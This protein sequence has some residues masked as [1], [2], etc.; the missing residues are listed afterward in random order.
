MKSSSI[1]RRAFAALAFAF[2]SLILGLGLFMPAIALAEDKPPAEY[3]LN[4]SD[5]QQ[6]LAEHPMGTPIEISA[7]DL[8]EMDRENSRRITTWTEM[9]KK[10][11][12]LALYVQRFC[13]DMMKQF[14]IETP[15]AGDTRLVKRVEPCHELEALMQVPSYSRESRAL[16]Y[17]IAIPQGA[18]TAKAGIFTPPA[19]GMVWYEDSDGDGWGDKDKSSYRRRGLRHAVPIKGDCDDR[20]AWVSP[21][22]SEIPNGIDDNCDRQIDEGYTREDASTDIRVQMYQRAQARLAANLPPENDQDAYRAIVAARPMPVPVSTAVGNDN[23][24]SAADILKKAEEAELRMKAIE[25]RVRATE[26]RID[27]KVAAAQTAQTGSEKARDE[28]V[29]VLAKI[30]ELYNTT[31]AAWH[32]TENARSEVTAAEGRIGDMETRVTE[33]EEQMQSLVDDV[34]WMLRSAEN[35]LTSIQQK[36]AETDI[37]IDR[38]SVLHALYLF[39]SLVLMWGLSILATRKTAADR[40][41][42]VAARSGALRSRAAAEALFDKIQGIQTW[43]D[44]TTKTVFA[45]ARGV[46]EAVKETVRARED[47]AAIQFATGTMCRAFEAYVEEQRREIAD[48]TAPVLEVGL[49][50][51]RWL[52]EHGAKGTSKKNSHANGSGNGISNTS[53]GEGGAG[54]KPPSDP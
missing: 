28:S 29:G 15:D 30:R 12:T 23:A 19:V 41:A 26:T 49:L 48:Q 47:V 3:G 22:A 9:A 32:G 17:R 53:N 20:N 38:A 24:G 10:G 16:L 33:I 37:K 45:D 42:A 50:A 8:A 43:M 4:E 2:L 5:R 36:F 27:A 31:L 18:A 40:K 34:G 6:L 1:N 13:P 46:T 11:N 54:N 52:R 39:L 14:T 25:E 21:E 44:T 51:K 35:V 7:A